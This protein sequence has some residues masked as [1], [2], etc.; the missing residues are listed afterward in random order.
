MSWLTDW[1]LS[2]IIFTPLLGIV[3]IGLLPSKSVTGT[4]FT[5]IGTSFIPFL[6]A[7]YVF[8][9]H[10]ITS[11]TILFQEKVEWFSIHLIDSGEWNFAYHLGVDGLSIPFLLL[12][13][14]LVMIAM[15]ASSSIRNRVKTFYLLLLFLE[16]GVTGVFVSQ[17]LLLFFLFFEITLVA[18]FFLIGIWGQAGRIKAAFYFLLYNGIGSAILLVAIL[19]I[20]IL[21]G[22]TEYPE[23]RTALAR[24]VAEVGT[25]VPLVV[26]CFVAFLLAFAIKLPAFPFHTWMLRVHKE[27]PTSVVMI[28]SGVL[29]KIGS[30]GILRF[31]VEWFPTYVQ[32]ASTV[33]LV[34]GLINLFY[35]AILAYVQKELRLVLAYS[36]ISHMGIIL[37]GIAAG[38]QTGLQGAILQSISHGLLSALLFFLVG[39]LVER[40]NSTLL[41]DLG[42]LAKTMP[43]FSGIFLV[44]G[45]GLLGLPGLSGFIS[46]FYA[47]MGL[48]ET[49]PV[50]AAVASLGLILA[51]LYVLRAV[52]TITFGQTKEK[53]TEWADLRLS[54]SIPM[55]VLVLAIIWIGVAPGNILGPVQQTVEAFSWMRGQ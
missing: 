5:A 8:W 15:I 7:L 21:I 46:E 44:G 22:T 53:A 11:S 55:L 1:I 40:S 48:Y 9:N 13:T 14:F 19:V 47:L 24:G 4:R 30:Y 6:L 2:L 41:S 54:E 26:A 38:T 35:G 12:A 45:L 28:H 34:L 25:E 17:N 37:L 52:L 29:L 20:Q 31:G 32:K 43:V 33:L 23:V 36:S 18:T 27:A 49:Q 3:V 39:S 16:I 42:G 10:Q 50:W 51:A